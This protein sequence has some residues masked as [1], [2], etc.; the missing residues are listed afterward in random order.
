M[1]FAW[2]DH[3]EDEIPAEEVARIDRA[4]RR[5]RATWSP[6][7]RACAMTDRATAGAGRDRASA[8]GLEDAEQRGPAPKRIVTG[9][10]FWIFLLSDIV[11]FSALL[12]GLRGAVGAD[13]R[14]PERRAS[15]ST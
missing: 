3:D 10:G 2:R 7:R 5:A 13:R 9:Y 11:M 1:V 12:R 14:R 4:N 6:L 15:C 8:S